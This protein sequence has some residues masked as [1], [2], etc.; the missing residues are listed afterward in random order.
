MTDGT[1]K[2]SGRSIS[3]VDLGA[4]II[5]AREAGLLVAG[6]GHAMAAGLTVAQ[7]GKIDAL[8]E[9]LDERL[10]G[11]VSAAL[12]VPKAHPVGR[13]DGQSARHEARCW[14]KRS[15]GQAP[16]APAGPGRAS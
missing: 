14:S 8:S 10:A 6:G 13:R 16:M 9:W 11:D 5:S 7:D 4:A 15:K 3:G 1:G 2:G 12:S